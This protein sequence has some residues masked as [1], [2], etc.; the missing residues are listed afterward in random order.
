MVVTVGVHK[1]ANDGLGGR[2]LVCETFK[3]VNLLDDWNCWVLT[4]AGT[5]IPM[6]TV[7]INAIIQMVL[8]AIVIQGRI[9]TGSSNRIQHAGLTPDG[10]LLGT[11]S[12]V[13]SSP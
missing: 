9:V 7:P 6:S 4:L 10:Y 13:G 8:D 12:S 5:V 3:S 11:E 1:E 2:N